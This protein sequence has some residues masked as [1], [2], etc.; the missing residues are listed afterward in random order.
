MRPLVIGT[1]Y[2]KIE[3]VSRRLMNN[4]YNGSNR[5]IVVNCLPVKDV[6]RCFI[7]RLDGAE[8]SRIFLQRTL[9]NKFTSLVKEAKKRGIGVAIF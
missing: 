8:V 1:S 7:E 2:E 5:P 9:S 6:E 3:E 4:G